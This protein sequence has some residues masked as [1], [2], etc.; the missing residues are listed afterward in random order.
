MLTIEVPM[1][2]ITIRSILRPF[3]VVNWHQKKKCL[4][5]CFCCDGRTKTTVILWDMHAEKG[6]RNVADKGLAL[7]N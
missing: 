1:K 6:K 5:T 2:M 3:F 7:I 4:F